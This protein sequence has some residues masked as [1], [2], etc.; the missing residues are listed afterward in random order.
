MD[1]QLSKTPRACREKRHPFPLPRVNSDYFETVYWMFTG[2]TQTLAG[3]LWLYIWLSLSR[4]QLF[5]YGVLGSNGRSYITN[6]RCIQPC[7]RFPRLEARLREKG[8]NTI[9]LLCAEWNTWQR[10]NDEPTLVLHAERTI[11]W[12][13]LPISRG[14]FISKPKV[15]HTCTSYFIF[16][17]VYRIIS[18]CRL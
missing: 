9:C 16:M 5:I 14:I 6:P 15:F 2:H 4:F 12:D 7:R 18:S 17:E 11:Y 13:E 10:K 3:T 8:R 1:T